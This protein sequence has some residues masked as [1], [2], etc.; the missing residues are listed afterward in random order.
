MVA[1][2]SITTPEMRTHHYSGHFK[3]CCYNI[4]ITMCMCVPVLQPEGGRN[5]ASLGEIL[6]PGGTGGTVV[7]I[8]VSGE[9]VGGEGGWEGGRGEAGEGVE[10]GH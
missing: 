2:Y 7:H 9:V 6:V 10:G 5:V 3:W 1:S 8:R 4:D